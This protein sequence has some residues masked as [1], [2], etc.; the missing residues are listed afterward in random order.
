[1][2]IE[3]IRGLVP[4]AELKPAASDAAIAECEHDLGHPLGD[5]LRSLLRETNGVLGQYELGL[6]WSVERITADNIMFRS[7]PDF[8]ALYMPFE[9]LLFFADAGNGDQFAQ[10]MRN[11]RQDVFVWEHE[12]DSRRWV[13]PRITEYLI[14][15][16]DGR[17]LGQ[18]R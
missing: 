10:V 4:V 2:W 6:V 14:W 12:T 16:I 11:S 8:A 18:V 13:A 9:P 3:L 1:M 5:D 15:W 17:Q 7:S